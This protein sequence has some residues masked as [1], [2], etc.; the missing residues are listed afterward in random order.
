MK[1]TVKG[2]EVAVIPTRTEK[3]LW[4]HFRF[5]L[6]KGKETRLPKGLAEPLIREGYA[7][8]ADV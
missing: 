5:E 7:T 3:I 1:N 8:K 6:E 4:G 2:K